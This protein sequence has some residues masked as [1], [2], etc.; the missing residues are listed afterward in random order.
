MAMD[1]ADSLLDLVGNTPLVRLGRIGRGRTCDLM[2]KMEHTNP[3]GSVRDRPAVAM[4]D[5]AESDGLLKPGGTII[6]PTS[7]NTGV[8]LAIVAAQR[9]YRCIFVM[10]DKMSEEKVALLRAYGADVVVCPTAVPP[11]HPDSYYSVADRLTR[12]TPGAFRPDQYSNPANPAEHERST[13]PEIWR[14]TDS[15]VTHFV[16]RIGTGGTITG[17]PRYL[18][19]RNPDVQ[20]VGADPEGSVYSGDTGRPYLV[21]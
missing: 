17:V 2:A 10:S 21:E 15:R 14:Q 13:G 8:G 11:E 3:S 12:E 9:G 18:K 4:V 7:G 20:I 16:A 19:R 1:V 5:A 6:E